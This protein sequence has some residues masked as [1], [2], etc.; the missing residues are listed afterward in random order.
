M[1]SQHECLK[2]LSDFQVGA[3][4]AETG[5]LEKIAGATDDICVQLIFNNAGYM[6]SGFFESRSGFHILYIV[7]C[8]SF[9]MRLH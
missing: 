9:Y 2:T 6:L 1:C 8:L 7:T 3:N 5:Y 4:L